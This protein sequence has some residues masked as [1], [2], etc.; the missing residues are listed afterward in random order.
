MPVAASAHA[1]EIDQMTVLTHW[2]M[3]ILF[4][5]W[6]AFFIYMLVRFRQGA[7]PKANY[8][9]VKSHMASYIEWAVAVVELVLIVAFA[10]PAWA[11][12]VDAFPAESEATVVRVVAE[13]F[14]WNV[15][16]PGADGQFGRTDIKLV[17]R[18]QPARPRSHPIRRRRTTSTRSTSWLCRSTSR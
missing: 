16:Y 6:G 14:A 17:S 12:R 7:N 15:H 4:V 2:L 3:P 18:G 10:I 1:A 5:G 8:E 9:G 13:Q 11:A